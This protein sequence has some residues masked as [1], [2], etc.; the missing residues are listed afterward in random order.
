MVPLLW[1]L[2]L[3][4]ITK[5]AT[6][7]KCSTNT[8]NCSKG[9]N[10]RILNPDHFH[11]IHHTSYIIHYTS[12]IIHHKSLPHI[13]PGFFES[14]STMKQIA[15]E[16]LI[17]VLLAVSSEPHGTGEHSKHGHLPDDGNKRTK[18]GPGP[19][20]VSDNSHVK[21]NGTEKKRHLCSHLH[22]F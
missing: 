10:N 6:I 15:T 18:D 5:A 19:V 17:L 12:Y 13:K 3:H 9:V 1:L 20:M 21:K 11:I 22:N 2:R 8:E 14:A 16:I 4:T 7:A